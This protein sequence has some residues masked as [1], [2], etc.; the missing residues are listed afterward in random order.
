MARKSL[1]HGFPEPIGLHRK[2]DKGIAPLQDAMMLLDF[3]ILEWKD[4]CRRAQLL[5]REK[6]GCHDLIFTPFTVQCA[7]PFENGAVVRRH[8]EKDIQ[9]GPSRNK[10]PTYGAAVEQHAFQLL[11]EHAFDLLQD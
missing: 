9:I 1:N 6:E 5:F 10:F 11:P 2:S 7:V 3:Q 4:R 8:Q